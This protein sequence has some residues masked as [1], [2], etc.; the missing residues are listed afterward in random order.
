VVGDGLD[1]SKLFMV[2]TTFLRAFYVVFVPGDLCLEF[3]QIPK[4]LYPLPVTTLRQAQ[5]QKLSSELIGAA[6]P[7]VGVIST[8]PRALAHAPRKFFGLNIPDFYIKQ[9][10]AHVEKLVK[11][12]KSTK[13]PTACLLQHSAEAMWVTLGCNGKLFQIPWQVLVLL[14]D[15]WL[16]STW[17][18][19]H[20][21]GISIKDDI[22]ELR[23]WREYDVLLIPTFLQMGYA[24]HELRLLNM[25][26][27]FYHVSWLSK[28]CSGDG[29][30]IIRCYMDDFGIPTDSEVRYPQQIRPPQLAWKVWKRA[31]SRLCDANQTLHRPLGDCV[32]HPKWSY[33]PISERLFFK[34]GESSVEYQAL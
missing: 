19:V 11:L 6:L 21:Y 9:G 33:D 1:P 20:T 3:F 13:H 24:G 12:S 30:R 5:C 22:P 23:A 2:I 18:F 8:F 25:C 32:R 34:K 29:L 15:S 26:R 16:K 31:L 4:K 28:I 14:E 10:V 17:D 27:L 7:Q